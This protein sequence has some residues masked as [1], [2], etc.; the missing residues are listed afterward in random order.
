[1]TDNAPQKVR[2]GDFVNFPLIPQKSREVLISK[3]Y[4][5][6]FPIQQQC[7]APVYEGKDLIAR[8]LTGSGKTFAFGLPIVERLRAKGQLGKGKLQAIILA[9]TREL[10][11][12]ITSEIQKLK[13][14]VEEF[15]VIAVY[16]G[17]STMNQANALKSGADIFVG[18]TGRVLDHMEKGNI[19]FSEVKTIVLDEAD[20][21]LKMG[22]KEDIEKILEKAKDETSADLQMLLFSA[23]IPDW[24]EEIAEEHMKEDRAIV[25]LAQ[26]LT[27]R[28]AKNIAH[29]AIE[30]P[31]WERMEALS[32]V[33]KYFQFQLMINI[34]IFSSL[35]RR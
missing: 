6:L 5:S 13:H 16:G 2:P 21:M 31:F 10:V 33:R 34:F 30:C 26:D 17:V 1:M 35:L 25:D 22:F 28:T 20:V 11:N 18:T 27:T 12:Q 3:G 9:P 14:A 7:F 4:R 32:K 29:F 23:T 19:D 15:R 8:D 24:I